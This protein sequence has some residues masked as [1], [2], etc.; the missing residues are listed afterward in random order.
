VEGDAPTIGGP[1]KDGKYTVKNVKRGIKYRVF[2]SGEP[3]GTAG[4]SQEEV[5]KLSQEELD[6]RSQNPIPDDAQGNNMTVEIKEA[7][8]AFDVKLTKKR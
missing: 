8:Q 3:E 6:R 7:N 1:I 5:N 4:M 2:A